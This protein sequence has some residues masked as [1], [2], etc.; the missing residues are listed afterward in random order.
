M[1]GHRI[2]AK[3]GNQLVVGGDLLVWFEQAAGDVVFNRLLD[4]QEEGTVIIQCRVQGGC[5]SWCW[6]LCGA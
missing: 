3:E 2:D 6:V 5:L 4:L 1:D